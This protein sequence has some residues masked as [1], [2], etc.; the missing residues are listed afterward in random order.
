MFRDQPK[1][2][3]MT[4][5]RQFIEVA[6][7]QGIAR[8]ARSL[9][10]TQPALSKNLKR[11]EEI[12]GAAL[13]ERHTKGTALTSAGQALYQRALKI[14]LEYEHA[15]QEVRNALD[16][17]EG[18]LRIGAGPVFSPTIIPAAIPRFQKHYPKYRISVRSVPA[19]KQEEELDLGR[20]DMVASV[21]P[22]THRPGLQQLPIRR[23]KMAILCGANHPL[24]TTGATVSLTDIAGF[25]F[26]S[27]EPDHNLIR[28]L[29]AILGD[30]GAPPP[31]YAVETS[32][33]FGAVELLRGGTHLMYG[34]SLLT[35]YPIGR[36]LVRL[37]VEGDLGDYLMGFLM[38]EG[39]EREPAYR[40]FMNIV[41]QETMRPTDTTPRQQ[42]T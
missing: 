7:E 35:E 15:L 6:D 41:R 24:A 21:L 14:I 36:G 8:A 20:V 17:D 1:F 11:L 5:L 42:G 22:E 9:N 40:G 18:L 23:V 37:A 12:V 33:I 38:R 34:S 31:S 30:N 25:P 26:L 2:P 16:K 3:N 39:K 27:F 29:A 32:S 13:F 10:M 28:K 19:E 4:L